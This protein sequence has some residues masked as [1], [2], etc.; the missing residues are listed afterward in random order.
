[1]KPLSTSAR[2]AAGLAAV[3]LALGLASPAFASDDPTD[4]HPPLRASPSAGGPGTEVTVTARCLPLEGVV[5]EAFERDFTLS[6]GPGRQWSGTGTVKQEGLTVGET[7]PITLICADGVI[8][9]TSFTFTGV[10]PTGGAAAGFGGPQADGTTATALATS[11]I[12]VAGVLAHAFRSRRRI[13]LATA[14]YPS[15]ERA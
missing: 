14:E 5:S 15:G 4:R 6:E 8:L 2:A 10:P 9:S 12:A 11:G 1:M 3:L 13:G 7:Y